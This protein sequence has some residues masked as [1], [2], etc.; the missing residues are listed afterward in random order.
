MRNPLPS[1]SRSIRRR[2]GGRDGAR[3]QSLVE[4]ALALP[5]ILLLTLIALDFGRVYLGY[6]NLQNMAR[7]GANYAA[8]DPDAWGATPDTDA[9]T[10]Y[11]NQILADAAATNCTL[12]Q[13]GGQPV[14][15]APVFTD[16]TGD[17]NANGLGDVGTV[18]ITCTF[19]VI[20]PFISNILGGSVQ[21]TAESN[22]AVKTGMSAVASGGGTPTG[23]SAPNAA[24]SANSTITPN[25]ITVIGPV[26]DVEFRDT[27]GGNPTSWAW[28]F[29]DGTTS[30]DQDPL[31][32][33]FTCAFSSCSYVVTMTATNILGSSMASMT[34]TVVGISDVNFTSDK[35]SGNAPLA[36]QFDDASTP[37]GTAWDWD[38]GDG[39][40]GTGESV[41]HT[42]DTPGTYDV[43]LT[44][45]YPDPIG[46]LS[47]TKVGYITAA[48][49]MCTIPS[50]DG[51]RFNDAQGIWQ[52]AP[53]NFTGIVIRGAGAPAGNFIITAQSL[54]G[55]DPA[56]CNSDVTVN[57]P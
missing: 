35:Q 36:V 46:Q 15:P 28:N 32:H 20:T 25:S 41:S 9:Q 21:V 1:L 23:G 52:G 6:I 39:D 24:F 44:V 55:T 37:G 34:V 8:N 57:R 31:Q 12:P 14:V 38:F 3:G 7:I 11:R 18:R 42:Y 43:T 47:T 30:N 22:F 2:A 50:L 45:T 19:G 56:P 16:V 53:Y 13:S 17:G 48:V 29:A 54:T 33:T 40:T 10:Q 27:S 4:L 51:V 5:I 49:G 26:V